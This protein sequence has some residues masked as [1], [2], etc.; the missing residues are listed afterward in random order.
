LLD[1]LQHFVRLV[2]A[3]GLHLVPFVGGSG[4]RA[5]FLHTLHGLLRLF[6]FRANG[7]SLR[8]VLSRGGRGRGAQVLHTAHGLLGLFEGTATGEAA[9]RNGGGHRGIVVSR[10]RSGGGGCAVATV[11]RHGSLGRRL[12]L[13]I[14]QA[15]VFLL[16]RRLFTL[17]HG[18]LGLEIQHG[19]LELFV[20][21]VV[22]GSG[23]GALLVFHSRRAMYRPKVVKHTAPAL[24][25]ATC[26][27]ELMI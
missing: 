15:S 8:L 3:D 20:A 10:S 2:R 26:P 5:Q 22:T 1:R 23:A 7:G 27:L 19:L 13:F 6:V 14:N 21:V 17:Q 9:K 24:A 16:E 11:V 4:R 18:N 25:K 12:V